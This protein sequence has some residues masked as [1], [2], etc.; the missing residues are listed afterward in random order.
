MAPSVIILVLQ[1]LL[2]VNAYILERDGHCLIIDPG[3]EKERIRRFIEERKW[4]VEG[5]LLTHGHFDHTGAVD[6]FPVPVYLHEAESAFVSNDQWNG[7]TEFG[8]SRPW[9]MNAL[10]LTKLR[11]G[12][13]IPFQ[14]SQV[15]VLHTPG[16]TPGSVCYRWENCL[17][18]GDT[19]FKEAVGRWDFPGGDGKAL[20]QSVVS[21]IEN[22]E[23]SVEVYPGHGEPTTIGQEREVNPYYH[24]W[25]KYPL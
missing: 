8:I 17:F 20:R 22:L 2:E 9:N 12:D 19:L 5:I 25:K 7:Y 4:I 18:S 3:F 15:E 13:T 14:E 6:V 24:Q 21:L 10:S 23:P 1:G 16:H 11:H